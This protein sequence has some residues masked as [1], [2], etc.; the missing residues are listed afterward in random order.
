MDT[1]VAVPPQWFEA[2]LGGFL[3]DLRRLVEIDC[4][5][6]DKA[7]VDAVGARFRAMLE[8]AGLAVE[9]V[10]V[11]RY[12]DCLLGT[13]RGEGAGRL[14]LMG[15]LDTVYP[16]GTAR[17]RPL[18]REGSRLVG[19]GVNDMK[20]GLLAGLYAV[21]GL[22][23]GGFR[24]FERIDFFCNG[25]EEVGSR[26]SRSLYADVVRAADVVLVLEAARADG[27]I[28][29]ARK[30]GGRFHL[31]VAGR[32]AHAGV[33]PE[34]GANAALELAHRVVAVN[35]LGGMRPGTTVSVGVLRSGSRANVVPDLAEAEVDVRVARHE[36][37][38][39]VEAALREAATAST[40]PGTSATIDGRFGMLPM[41]R[42][43]AIAA[44]V[45]LARSVA[46]ELG[47]V[48]SDVA[49]GGM[50]DA[51]H[52]AALERPVLDGLG[53]VGGLDHSPGEYVEL[54]SIVPRTALL[55]GLCAAVLRR[56][57][58]GRTFADTV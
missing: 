20:A 58:P 5:S 45:E 47:F 46:E 36:D 16:V 28:V 6:L 52:V 49:T 41:V 32:S 57:E 43:P 14:L 53:P 1:L 50:S 31:T 56:I 3:V 37:M 26:A 2:R 13:V 35:A 12:G 11:E 4:G 22:M 10:P 19:P 15:H 7:G 17:E 27:S 51:N 38:E 21:E 30:G 8:R 25:D 39:P 44:L 42:T 54:E 29:S 18:R 48:L 33:E 40:V 34:K 9:T 55:A 24:D 23:E